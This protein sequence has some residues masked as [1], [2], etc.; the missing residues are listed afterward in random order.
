[1]TDL[2]Y[3]DIAFTIG[4]FLPENKTLYDALN[5]PPKQMR[6]LTC[7]CNDHKLINKKYRKYV[8]MVIILS[9]DSYRILYHTNYFINLQEL[10]IERYWHKNMPEPDKI[11]LPRL[12]KLYVNN[13]H[14]NQSYDENIK[15]FE[16]CNKI[17]DLMMMGTYNEI[18]MC[19]F[20]N[21]LD[22]LC[23]TCDNHID[24]N[25]FKNSYITTLMITYDVTNNISLKNLEKIKGVKYLVFNIECDY[26]YGREDIIP[27]F[28]NLELLIINT[29]YN[30]VPEYYILYKFIDTK[31]IIVNDIKI[32]DKSHKQEYL[33][34]EFPKNAES[35]YHNNSDTNYNM[36]DEIRIRNMFDDIIS[37]YK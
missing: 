30:Y 14:A 21:K 24:E 20:N 28:P 3:P 13:E 10:Y 32:Y 22:T 7:I 19:Y 9:L 31:K 35:I 34:L 36:N 27:Y 37:E 6:D 11:F 25:T 33:K 12:E 2:I 29:S 4:E 15:A 26:S 18:P 1:M 23:I 16:K 5:I 17:K 8:K